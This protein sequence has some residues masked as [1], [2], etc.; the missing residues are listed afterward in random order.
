M[1]GGLRA[2]AGRPKGAVTIKGEKLRSNFLEFLEDNMPQLQKDFDQLTPYQKWRTVTAMMN[3]LLPKQIENLD[4][5]EQK[6]V[7]M[8]QPE[9]LEPEID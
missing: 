6:I 9:G 7:F 3:R 4:S 1:R 5:E 2:G 8:I